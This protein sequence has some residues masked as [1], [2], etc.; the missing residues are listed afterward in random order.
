MKLKG[1]SVLADLL[2]RYAIFNLSISF[3]DNLK[4]QRMKCE[5]AHYN[6]EI[7]LNYLPGEFLI[8]SFTTHAA[9]SLPI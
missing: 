8:F 4:L 3:L 1:G 2:L 7:D 5:K 9:L 6:M